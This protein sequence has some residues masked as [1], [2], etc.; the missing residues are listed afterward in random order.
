[1]L[2]FKKATPGITLDALFGLFKSL[3]VNHSVPRPP[4]SVLIFSLQDVQNITDYVTN[5]YVFFF[6]F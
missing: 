4:Y 5:T 6:F 3:L 1:M 2:F